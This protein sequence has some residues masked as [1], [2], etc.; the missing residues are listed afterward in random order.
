MFQNNY[1]LL[2]LIVTNCVPHPL[3]HYFLHD[4]P[5]HHTLISSHSLAYDYMVK[6]RNSTVRVY[7]GDGSSEPRYFFNP[8]N[9]TEAEKS[10]TP[11]DV[12]VNFYTVKV[13]MLKGVVSNTVSGN[14]TTNYGINWDNSCDE[15]VENGC[16]FDMVDCVR[17]KDCGVINDPTKQAAEKMI[18]IYVTFTGDDSISNPLKSS[19]FMPSR[20]RQFSLGKYYDSI[21]KSIIPKTN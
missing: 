17:R 1:H 3:L 2:S 15:N 14:S 5:F 13:T 12:M 20:F 7:M 16:I 4:T 6:N 19:S 21:A 9:K 18:K 8:V 11:V 10:Q